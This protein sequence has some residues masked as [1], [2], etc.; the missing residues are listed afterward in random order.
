[1]LE[2]GVTRPSARS[3]F[4]VPENGTIEKIKKRHQRIVE[5]IFSRPTSG[6]VQWRDVESLFIELGAEIEERAGGQPGLCFFVRRSARLS[7]TA[8]LAQDRQG[9]GGR[10]PQMAGTTWS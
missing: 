7:P 6:N 10:H 8:S 5:L 2:L 3:L 4:S 1:M 9:R